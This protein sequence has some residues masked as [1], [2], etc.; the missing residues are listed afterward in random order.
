M[1]TR[2]ITTEILEGRGINGDDYVHLDLTHLGA[3]KMKE[4]LPEITGF[5]RT[6][7]G[8]DPV[9]QPIPILPTAHYSMGGIPTDVYGQVMADEKNTPIVGF[10]AAGE[11]ACVSVHGANRLG[12]NSLLDAVLHGRRTGRTMTKFLQ[13]ADRAPLPKDAADEDKKNLTVLFASNGKE[14]AA[15]IRAELRENMMFKCGVFR[16][17]KDLNEMLNLVHSYQERYKHINMMDK[18]DIFNTDLM[19]A[20]ELSHLLDFSEVIVLG[21]LARRECRGAHWRT[22]FA[23]RDDV[24]WLKHTV[25]FKTEEGIQL[26]YK[27]VVITKYQPMERTY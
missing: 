26:K 2:S 24:N 4:R 9:K 6:Y 25:A 23:K 16:N 17:E 1:V 5:A 18:G 15:A 20:L 13:Q 21:A 8:I 7:A 27:P 12:T 11:C 3:A 10:Y 14:S 22:D 19:E